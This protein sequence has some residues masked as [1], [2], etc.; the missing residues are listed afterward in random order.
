MG[1]A[2]SSHFRPKAALKSL[3]K[4][5]LVGTQP[6]I[7]HIVFWGPNGLTFTWDILGWVQYRFFAS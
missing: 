4:L 7:V 6:H 1:Q 2:M 3:V 5:F